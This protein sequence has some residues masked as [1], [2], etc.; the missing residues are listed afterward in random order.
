MDAI[1][2]GSP[3]RDKAQNPK[4]NGWNG[5][6]DVGVPI[7][8]QRGHFVGSP[9]GDRAQ[10]PKPAVPLGSLLGSQRRHFVGSPRRPHTRTH[11]TL[12]DR[13]PCRPLRDP[14]DGVL[15]TGSLWDPLPP[16][17]IPPPH[18][19]PHLR[20]SVWW[21]PTPNAARSGSRSAPSSGCAPLRCQW[22]CGPGSASPGS[23]RGAVGTAGGTL[24][25]PPNRG[26]RWGH[27][28]AWG[29]RWGYT[30]DRLGTSRSLGTMGTSQSLGTMATQWGYPKAWGQWGHIG[31]IPKPG[32]ALGTSQGLGG[33]WGHNGDT[34][35]PGGDVG[36][37][38][39]TDWGHPEAWG[40]W[41]HNGDTVGTP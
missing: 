3:R 34:P 20:R 11:P 32:G 41:G 2:I 31:D 15:Y 30:G 18:I 33:R 36:D 40:Q 1:F 22:G 16:P 37:A 7:G 8:S 35:R 28:K 13:P 17:H 14:I 26:G 25:T 24:G 38:L 12:W 10:D 39:G 9:R 4:P 27:L 21:R 5:H 23:E 6:G 29:G 19:P